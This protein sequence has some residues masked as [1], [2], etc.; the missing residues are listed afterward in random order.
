V[1]KIKTIEYEDVKTTIIYLRPGDYLINNEPFRIDGYDWQE[2]K[3]EI[4]NLNNIRKIE[5]TRILKE[6]QDKDGDFLSVEEYDKKIKQLL[7]KASNEY[8]EIF[9]DLDDEYNYKKFKQKWSPIYKTVQTISEPLKLSKKILKLDTGNPYI[10]TAFGSIK[11]SDLEVYQYFQRDARI[12][13]LKN[14]MSELGMEFVE[15]ANYGAT[16]GKYIY[17]ISHSGIRYAV[18]FGTYIFSDGDEGRYIIT[19][20]Y[21]NCNKMYEN[22]KKWMNNKI[23]KLYNKHFY[24]GDLGNISVGEL[25]KKLNL[26]KNNFKKV[27]SYKKTMHEYNTGNKFLKEA[28]EL[29]E[30]CYK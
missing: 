29:L 16:E 19:D 30:K 7:S 1:S 25:L 20:T 4:K 8:D 28:I 23:Q 27:N 11:N 9:K 18:A 24:K 10:K 3:I 13:F 5:T 15:K 2:K 22:D 21:D 14:K 26:A 6:Y 12:N 17:S